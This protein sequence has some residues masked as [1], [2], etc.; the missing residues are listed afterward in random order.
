M[1]RPVNRPRR[2]RRIA[3]LLGVG[4]LCVLATGATTILLTV[5]RAEVDMSTLVT[6]PY[7]P[8][9]TQ[10]PL[11]VAP[12]A[13][14]PM[15]TRTLRAQPPRVTS[16]GGDRSPAAVL[17]A[18]RPA[19]VSRS[20]RPGRGARGG[21]A[22]QTV[23]REPRPSSS[24]LDHAGQGGNPR[25]HAR[26]AGDRQAGHRSPDGDQARHRASRRCPHR[27]PPSQRPPSRP[28]R[29]RPDRSPAPIVLALSGPARRRRPSRR[30]PG[31]SRR[32]ACWD[33][34]PVRTDA[35]SR[36]RSPA[37]SRPSPSSPPSPNADPR[38]NPRPSTRAFG[39]RGG[40]AR[41]WARA[42]GAQDPALMGR[43][44]RGGASGGAGRRRGRRGTVRPGGHARR[45]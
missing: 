7:S 41:R 18:P 23:G 31:R 9:P 44:V 40:A 19:R 25:R 6:A 11:L 13:P 14:L 4:A 8:D 1:G 26:K 2:I 17:A 15:P 42:R 45:R 27:P 30:W 20:A 38:S 37:A 10:G 36:R 12:A 39:R 16:S 33:W 34:C 43:R 3:Q 32:R 29:S 24:D 5:G 22:R 21:Q 35:T 28:R